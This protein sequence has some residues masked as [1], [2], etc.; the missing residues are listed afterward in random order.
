MKAAERLHRHFKDQLNLETIEK[1]VFESYELLD[2]KSEV[3]IYLPSLTERFAKDRLS[4]LLK[5]D[6]L[7]VSDTLDVLFVCVHNSGR[8]QMAAGFMSQLGGDRVVVRSAGS[9]PR[10]SISHEVIEAMA[11]VGIDIRQ[12]FPKPLTDEVV[13]G[14]DAVITMGCG[15]ACPIYPGKRYEDWVLEDPADQSIEAVRVIRDEIKKRVET[16]LS[17]LLPA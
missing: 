12:E 3:K 5:S 17:E 6:N 11:E 2:A 1:Y 10:E 8:S 9:A 7:Q 4:A 15:D 16:L 13:R 14:S